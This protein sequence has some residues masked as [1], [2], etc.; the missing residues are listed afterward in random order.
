MFREAIL[1]LFGLKEKTACSEREKEKC[2][3][4]FGR[5]LE[6]ACKNCEKNS[7]GNFMRH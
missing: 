7:A 2:R 5:H 6:W 1:T 3:F 4:E